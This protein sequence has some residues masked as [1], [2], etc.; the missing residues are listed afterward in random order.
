[1][2]TMPVMRPYSAYESDACSIART[3]ALVGDRW[4]L[5]VLRDVANGVRRFDELAGHLGVARNVLSGRLERL[6]RAGLV[7]RAAYREP[8][9]RERH[10]YRLSG[11]GRELIPVLLAVMQWGDRHLAGPAGPPTLV[12]HAGCGAPI[13]VSL[14]CE[15]GH[16]LGERPSLRLEP[17]PGSRMR[18]LGVLGLGLGLHPAGLS[19]PAVEY[20]RLAGD[21]GGG[22]G[23][24]ERDRAR[25]IRGYPEA[26]ERVGG[27]HLLLTALVQECGELRLHHGGRHR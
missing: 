3:L 19:Y 17:G 2:R 12:R 13:K 15:E 5:L 11:A 7:E 26:L 6:A 20:Q 25:D 8:G 22:V 14:T 4:T 9:A 23:Q 18:S 1:M 10:E 24:Q 16:E 27:R 21:P